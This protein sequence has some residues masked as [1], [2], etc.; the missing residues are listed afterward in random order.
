M[1]LVQLSLKADQAAEQQ[2]QPHP[3]QGVEQFRRDN[4]AHAPNPFITAYW[5]ELAPALMAN[6]Q[7]PIKLKKDLP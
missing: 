1:I 7:L 4:M 2:G 6:G 3:G 5:L